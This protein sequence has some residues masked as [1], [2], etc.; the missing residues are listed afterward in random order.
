MKTEASKVQTEKAQI[1]NQLKDALT[2]LSQF[3]RRPIEQMSKLPDW[4]WLQIFLVLSLSS[5]LSG[6][7]MGL[8]SQKIY[9]FLFGLFIFPLIS[10]IT[11]F[12]MGCFFFYYFQVFERRSV[13]FKKIWILVILSNLPFFLFQIISD[14]VPP[15]TLLGMAFSGMLLVV[16]LKE[17]FAVEKKRAL[18]LVGSLFF[19]VFS[20]WL[21]NRIDILRLEGK[22]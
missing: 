15:M 21:W 2:Y 12:V 11:Q 3:V 22:L 19:V 17:N 9:H 5:L 6:V 4:T 20:V 18:T 8:V 10:L 1:E 13:E 16:G 14:L 7:L